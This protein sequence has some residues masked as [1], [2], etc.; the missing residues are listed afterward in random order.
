MRVCVSLLMIAAVSACAPVEA[1]EISL[2]PVQSAKT[3]T[4]LDVGSFAIS[5]ADR[6]RVYGVAGDRLVVSRDGGV[7]WS[8]LTTPEY[9]VEIGG[10]AV[11]DIDPDRVWMSRSNLIWRSDDGGSSWT[12][13]SSPTVWSVSKIDNGSK[14]RPFHRDDGQRRLFSPTAMGA[15]GSRAAGGCRREWVRGRSSR[16]KTSSSSP[17]DSDTVFVVTRFRGVFKS[18]DEGRNWEAPQ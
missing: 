4:G 8:R 12:S 6:S 13:L 10:L 2:F 11:S 9:V 3:D 7:A 1:Q 15:S 18:D 14:R 16:S 17:T 5:L